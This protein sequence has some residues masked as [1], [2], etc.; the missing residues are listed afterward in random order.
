M[1]LKCPKCHFDNPDDTIYC[2]KCA[3][4]LKPSEEISAP[5]ETLETPMGV[6]TRGS[7]VAGRYEVIEEL[8]R[9]GMGVVY[10][11]KDT[12]LKRTVALKFL[13][14][15]LVRNIEAKE[16]LIHE[17]QAASALDHSNICTVYEIDEDK[18]QMFIAM[19]YIEGQGLREKIKK[20]PLKLDEALDI[21]LH[22]AEGLHEAHEKGI[23]HRDIK[24]ANIMLTAKDQAKIM[25]FGVAKL[26]GRTRF[27]RTGTTMG[28]IAYMSPEQ[29]HGERVDH[30][31][32]IW[33]LGVVLYE[34]VTGQ[35][36]FKGEYEQAVVYSILNEEPEPITGLRT[37]VPMELERIVNKTLA[38]SPN[39]RYQHADELSVD[40]RTLRNKLP[41]LVS[42]SVMSRPV[43]SIPRPRKI[44]WSLL[45]K[46]SAAVISVIAIVALWSV[47]RASQSVQKP[48]S[49]FTIN[50]PLGEALVGPGSSIALSRDGKN[51]VYI[52]KRG[53][54]AKLYLRP[55]DEF[56]SRPI[57]GTEGAT[58][59]FFS[60]DGKWV[61][62]FTGDKLKKVSLLGG[63][64]QD[65]CNIETGFEAFGACW[66]KDN[67][68]FFTDQ[69]TLGLRR[70]PVLGGIP[71]PVTAPL[72]QVKQ[73][74]EGTY[75]LPQVLPGGKAIL[76]SVTEKLMKSKIAVYSL[77]TKEYKFLIEGSNARYAPT[78]HLIYARGG[79]LLA[80]P[81][82]LKKLKVTG[83]PL[84]VIE[85]VLRSQYGTAHFDVSG[86]GVLVYVPGRDV[87]PKRSI[88][89]ADRRGEVKPLAQMTAGSHGCR[90]SPDGKH[91]VFKKG[92]SLW[93]Y[94][95]ERESVIRF[96]DD[97]SVEW[98]PLW[99]P[100]S[101]R[102][103]F[104][105]NLHGGSVLNLYWRPIEG[106]QAERLTE[107][108][109]YQQPQ[110][111][112]ADG[113]ELFFTQ[114]PHPKT[115]V[116]IW[117]LPFD[118]ERKP[119]PLLQTR[120]NEFH[121]VIS[122]D[123]NWLAYGSDE[124]GRWEVYVQPYPGLGTTTRIST[125]GGCEPLWSPDGR[126]LYYRNPSGKKMMAV[127]FI[128]EPNLR[129][130]KPEFLFEGEYFLC[131]YWGRSYDL[132]P[133]G[134]QFLLIT[135][136]E[137]QLDSKHYNVVINWFEELK[138]LVP[139]KE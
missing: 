131:S 10:K 73:E 74:F 128:T 43:P 41:D 75:C 87:V 1:T 4:T 23:V 12:K 36:P 126:E 103:V 28:T 119:R 34:M 95:L 86:N 14:P 65:I 16:R 133:D 124:T 30:R 39:E 130:G 77:E 53:D 60:P 135:G 137:Q 138:H 85:G 50:L 100:D 129:I 79:D 98:W 69:V 15:E 58:A 49:R 63:S 76:Y 40:L 7:T 118:G 62:F 110:S 42:S 99:T 111:W 48:V 47:W 115:G 61:G 32:D 104:N 37:G 38:K 88:I 56:E 21:A 6:L 24:S 27:T 68:I 123:G 13:S 96:T 9:G 83:T 89:W 97:E 71:E 59:P 17:A 19:A 90:L 122:P 91:L 22:V 94:E 52:G 72:E 101:K 5:T 55:I 57:P 51:V 18:G 120:F 80:V 105:S 20:G 114:G 134:E 92:R 106:G 45:W 2:G 44:Q 121:P 117:M 64:P 66:D 70:V 136:I 113:K 108:K 8:G 127:S 26:S 29:A 109:Y 81:F 67:T 82:D 132:A 25:D 11:A 46:I 31:T 33:S 139:T 107:S 125:D 54:I 78:G 84:P 116:D 35:L 112:S 3:T 102:V 93:L